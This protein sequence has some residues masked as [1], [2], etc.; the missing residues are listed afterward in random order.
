MCG[1]FGVGPTHSRYIE[2]L[3]GLL[4]TPKASLGDDGLWSLPAGDVRPGTHIPVFGLDRATGRRG[5]FRAHWGLVPHW[6]AGQAE[7]YESR[8]GRRA[9]KWKGRA[10]GHFNSR[11]DT[12]QGGPGWRDL[13]A[14]R[15]AVV[16]AD[17]FVEWSDEAMLGPGDLKKQA[18]FAMADGS[19]LVFAALWDAVPDGGRHFHSVSLITTA[20]NELTASLP[21]H[22]MPAL[23]TPDQV[24]VWL[25]P[26]GDEKLLAILGPTPASKM[27]M[28]QVSG[29]P[30][31]PSDG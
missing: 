22:R 7:I 13:A 28:K 20:P 4:E 23:L 27:T 30:S 24:P 31:F 6:A 2:Y 19:P 3:S 9:V 18:R 8:T 10:M 16:L 21:H 5:T 14:R 17:D 12:L 29:A 26:A 11:L 1:R 25:D 15:R